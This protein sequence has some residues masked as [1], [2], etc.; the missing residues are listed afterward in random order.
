M[1]II[2]ARLHDLVEYKNISFFYSIVV[3]PFEAQ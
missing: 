2:S 1:N 3:C